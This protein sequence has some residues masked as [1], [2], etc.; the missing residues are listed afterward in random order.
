[1][2]TPGHIPN[3][4]SVTVASSVMGTNR[5]LAIATA[6]KASSAPAG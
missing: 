3:T 6:A 1:M 2:G 4:V 5:Q